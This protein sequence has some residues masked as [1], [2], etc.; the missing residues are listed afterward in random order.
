MSRGNLKTSGEQ[1]AF[2]S[3][4]SIGAQNIHRV[5]GVTSGIRSH[6][7]DEVE[8][9]TTANDLT[10][11]SSM[12]GTLCDMNMMHPRVLYNPNYLF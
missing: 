8:T 6:L 10:F 11:L 4:D 5:G 2:T 12:G 1:P 9:D 3:N 7:F